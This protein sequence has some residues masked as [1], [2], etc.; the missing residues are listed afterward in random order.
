[1]ADLTTLQQA[2][3]ISFNQLSLLEQAMVHD[4]YLNEHPHFAL[5]SNERLEFLGDAVLGLI[6]A[7]KL[8]HDFPRLT[9]GEMTRLRSSLVRQDTLA[10]AAQSI[11]LGEHLYLGKGEEATGG[12]MKPANLARA[13]EAVI[14]AIFLDQGLAITEGIVLKLFGKTLQKAVR[15]GVAVDC[16]TQLQEYFQAKL[17]KIPTYRVV[18]TT[19]PPHERNFIVEVRIGDTLLGKGTGKSKKAADTE[20]ARSALERLGANFTL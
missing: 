17:K 18:A 6:I 2:L 7:Q 19:G 4:S 1:M 14:A 11:K 9:E 12:R 3:G 10:H 15:Q 16:K 20:A 8:Y 5:A 13:L